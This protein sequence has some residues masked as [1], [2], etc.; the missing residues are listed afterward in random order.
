MDYT[1]QNINIRL[2]N[3]HIFDNMPLVT[4]RR[5]NVA[6]YKKNA[7]SP[8]ISS[9]DSAAHRVVVVFYPLHKP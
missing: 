4:P 2:S 3:Q 9:P 5:C 8:L 1:L 6:I 7:P